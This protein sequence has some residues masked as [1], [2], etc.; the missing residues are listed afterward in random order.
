MRAAPRLYRDHARRL[1]CQ[2][3]QELL[4]RELFSKDYRSPSILTVQKEHMFRRVN[5]NGL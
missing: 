5:T 3:G 2:E 1:I 4:S